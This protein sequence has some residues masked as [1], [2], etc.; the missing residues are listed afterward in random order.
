MG[1]EVMGG[2][3]ES[4]G[5]EDHEVEAPEHGGEDREPVADEC[6]HDD[7]AERDPDRVP[8][9]GE[10]EACPPKVA[11]QPRLPSRDEIYVHDAMGHAQYRSWCESCVYGQGREYLH[12]RG[13]KGRA[14]PVLS[15]DYAFLSDHDMK[16]PKA[17][18]PEQHPEQEVTRLLIG[19][20]AKSKMH[21]AH[22]VQH[23]GVHHSS[24]NF[25]RV[26]D[27]IRK[28]GYNRLIVKSDKEPSIVAQI[29]EAQRITGGVEIVEEHSHTGDPQSNGE[30]EQAVRTIKSKKIGRAHV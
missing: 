9:Q 22:G 6:S 3:S 29:R 19:K 25:Q 10:E 18:D 30:V 24:W 16:N 12:L 5:Y 27:D 8:V 17:E 26:N 13:D 21:F 1:E 2:A 11:A 28:L 15:Y 23:K 20:D 7:E 4:N 14:L